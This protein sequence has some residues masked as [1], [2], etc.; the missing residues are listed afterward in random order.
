MPIWLRTFTYNE[1]KKYNEEQSAAIQ[2]AS[3]PYKG[4]TSYK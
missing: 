2:K 4:K 3:K 1:I